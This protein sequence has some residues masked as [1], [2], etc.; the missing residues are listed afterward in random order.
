MEARDN[1]LM[2]SF[3]GTLKEECVE[4]QNY[5]TRVEARNSVFEYIEVFYNRKR[6]HSSLGYSSPALYEQRREGT[7]PSTT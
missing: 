5:Q 7:E 1:A 3:F 6:R 4:R 2:E